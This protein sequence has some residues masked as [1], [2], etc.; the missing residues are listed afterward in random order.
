MKYQ[1]VSQKRRFSVVEC[2]TGITVFLTEKKALAEE[3]C[4]SLNRGSGFQGFTPN[5]FAVS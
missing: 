2:D 5:F 1:I 4:Q 3:I